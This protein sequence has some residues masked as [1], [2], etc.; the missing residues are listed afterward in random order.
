M[1]A[2]GKLESLW[3]YPHDSHGSL[4]AKAAARW[5]LKV[6]QNTAPHQGFI[7]DR[8]PPAGAPEDT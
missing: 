4:S 7:V 8:L 3:T 2:R 5:L 1:L 6:H